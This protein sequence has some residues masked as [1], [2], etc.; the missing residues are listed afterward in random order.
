MCEL[1][2]K[3][4]TSIIPGVRIALRASYIKFGINAH[5]VS[6]AICFSLSLFHFRIQQRGKKSQGRNPGRA[7]TVV[8]HHCLSPPINCPSPFDNHHCHPFT[9]APKPQNH[10]P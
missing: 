9:G 4:P 6:A 10:K 3:H 5:D 7:S 1:L 2:S 8:N